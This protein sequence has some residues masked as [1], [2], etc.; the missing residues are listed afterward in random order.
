MVL[1][2]IRIAES[3]VRFS[4]G[5]QMSNEA[6]LMLKNTPKRFIGVEKVWR[7]QTARIFVKM[8]IHVSTR[9]FFYL[10]RGDWGIH[11]KR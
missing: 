7:N 11:L 10:E 3:G 1:R 4:P 6:S 9:V 5:P 2:G 8:K